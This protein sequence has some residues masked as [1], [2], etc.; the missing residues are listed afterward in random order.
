MGNDQTNDDAREGFRNIDSLRLGTLLK[1][2][3][4]GKEK[5]KKGLVQKL[6]QREFPS[7]K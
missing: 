3:Q 4:Q 1:I 5:A 6:L 2:K 7:S